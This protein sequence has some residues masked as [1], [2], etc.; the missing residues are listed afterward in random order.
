MKVGRLRGV[1]SLKRRLLTAFLIL[2]PAAWMVSAVINYRAASLAVNEL[3]DTEQA[4]FAQILASVN[5]EARAQG[6]KIRPTLPRTLH[7]L[8]D[9]G[10]EEEMDADIAFQLRNGAGEIIIADINQTELPFSRDYKGF[11]NVRIDNREWRL[12]YLHD[13]NNDAF[14]LVGQRMKTRNKLVSRLVLGQM[15]PWLM[16]LPALLVLMWWGVRRSLRPVDRLARDVRERA[17]DNLAPIAAPVPAEVGPLVVALNRLFARLETTLANER[18][19]TADAAHELRTPLAALRVQLE[20]AMMAGDDVSRRRA[21]AKVM[22]GIDRATRLI[23]QLLT[24]ARLDHLAAAD[25]RPADLALCARRAVVLCADA[26]DTRAITLTA[27][28]EGVIWPLAGDEGMLEILLRNL[29]DNAIR[30]TPPG[31]EVWVEC[32][33]AALS[34]CDNGPGVAPEWLER[35]K[36]RF[37]RPEGQQASGS[38]LGLSIAERIAELH[39][40]KLTLDNRP[41]GGFIARLSRVG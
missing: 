40:L 21:L 16:A 41:G 15:M 26:A 4:F 31:G 13:R 32:D 18:R 22:S 9:D 17:P 33:A 11:Y 6:Y 35:V 5:L 30:Y 10:D 29:I 38:G 7:E 19:F 20:V 27:P 39:G 23:E 14:A 2:L 1:P 28:A 24:L 36:E 12:F 34:V 25:R 3:F 8:F 37:S